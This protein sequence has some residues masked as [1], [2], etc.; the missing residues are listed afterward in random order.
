LSDAEAKQLAER[1]AEVNR[2]YPLP[3]I[4]PAHASLLALA[5]CCATL[6]VPRIVMTVKTRG[7]KA[8]KAAPT[9]PVPQSNFPEPFAVNSADDN[10][11]V[12][13]GIRL[14]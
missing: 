4:N 7:K 8:D 10:G 11:T 12:F 3:V 13:G 1:I 6:Y 9:A 14:Q 5:T 2:H